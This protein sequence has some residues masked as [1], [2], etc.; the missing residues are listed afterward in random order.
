[1]RQINE[2]MIFCGITCI[3]KDTLKYIGWYGEK[4]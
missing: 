4:L 2:K 3:I 1:M